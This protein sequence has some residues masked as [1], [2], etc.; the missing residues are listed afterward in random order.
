MFLCYDFPDTWSHLLFVGAWDP[1]SATNGH[2][3]CPKHPTFPA[4]PQYTFTLAAKTT[5]VLSL[6]REDYRWRRGNAQYDSAVGFVIMTRN[7]D[8]VQVFNPKHMKAMA[9][10]FAKATFSPCLAD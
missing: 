1:S 4:N 2:G 8:R 9:P 10:S 5:L 6:A 7:A 3:G